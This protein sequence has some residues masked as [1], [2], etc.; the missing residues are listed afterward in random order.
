[1]SQNS[2]GAGGGGPDRPHENIENYIREWVCGRKC[3][4][5]AYITCMKK[6]CQLWIWG[7][8]GNTALFTELRNVGRAWREREVTHDGRGVKMGQSIKQK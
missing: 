3:P 4:C 8:G 2:A 1:M 7:A 5:N 6:E